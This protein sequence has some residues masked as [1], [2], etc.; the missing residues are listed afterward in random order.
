[1]NINKMEFD[2]HKNKWIA[3]ARNN[4][5]YA[6][7][8][9]IQVWVNKSGNIVDSVSVRGLDKDYVIDADTDKEITNYQIK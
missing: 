9:H 5:W 8:F 4:N 6:E 1:M 2:Y 7:P 3:V